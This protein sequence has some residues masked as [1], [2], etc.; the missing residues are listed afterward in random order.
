MSDRN[1]YSRTV[2]LFCIFGVLI[3]WTMAPIFIK[4]LTESTDSFTQNFFRYGVSALFWLPYLIVC[5]V[6]GKVPRKM[7][8][9]A[10]IPSVFN[11]CMQSCWSKTMYYLNPGM[12]SLMQRSVIIWVIIMTVIF[13]PEERSFV[14]RPSLWVGI[15]LVITGVFGVVYYQ[16]GFG[17]KVD[18]RG[19]IFVL[20]NAFFW[21]CYTI[22]IKKYMQELN[23]I[24]GFSLMSLYTS[25]GLGVLA[26]SFGE[27]MKCV[28]FSGKVWFYLIFSGLLAIALAHVLYVAAIQRIGTTLPV[29]IMSL[30]PFLVASAS[31]IVF[32]ENLNGWQCVSG[33]II[34]AGSMIAIVVQGRHQKQ[35]AEKKGE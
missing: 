32:H 19:V 15:L 34:I 20:G 25:I 3:C 28:E 9:L 11:V 6:R 27:P 22:A 2:G 26:F 12:A 21:S 30:M 31:F 1:G 4:L 10:M 29:I 16:P 33:C 8:L 23:A 5:T 14:K 7:W 18:H 17:D 35:L 24:I 13:Y